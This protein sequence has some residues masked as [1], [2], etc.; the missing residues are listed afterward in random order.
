MLVEI[1]LFALVEEQG[2]L[3]SQ[4]KLLEGCINGRAT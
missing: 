2:L 4:G 3:V 1:V